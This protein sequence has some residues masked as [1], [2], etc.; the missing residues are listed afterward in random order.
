MLILGW[1]FTRAKDILRT[2]GLISLINRV[3]ALLIRHIFSYSTVYL[4]EH[5][6]CNH[7]EADF[8]PRMQDLTCK[9]VSTNQQAS[10]VAKNGFEDIRSLYFSRRNLDNG[11][12]AFCIFHGQQL[13]H[14]GWMAMTKEAKSAFDPLPYQVYFSDNEA[15]TGGIFTV[16][17]YRGKGLM[18]YGCF[19]RFE[20]LRKHG[21]TTTRNAVRISN[22]TSQKVHG[23]FG[24]TIYARARHI[25]I[26]WWQ[27]WKE[28]PIEHTAAVEE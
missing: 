6:M 9:L 28:V 1:L 12:I 17:R 16:P 22:I 23:K 21:I 27:F 14:I 2:E 15:C 13:V 20:Y 19:K 10:E 24:P 3:V 4:Y 5:T 18:T 8:I 11:A 7:D 25:K 26:L